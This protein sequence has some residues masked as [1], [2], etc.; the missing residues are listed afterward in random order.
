MR[1]LLAASPEELPCSPGPEPS[2]T[3]RHPSSSAKCVPLHCSS[4]AEVA[5]STGALC[6]G[7]LINKVY[8][9]PAPQCLP[10]QGTCREKRSYFWAI[11]GDSGDERWVPLQTSFSTPQRNWGGGGVSPNPLARTREQDT[12]E[13]RTV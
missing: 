12:G 6:S 10:A 9:P 4:A 2:A 11:Q 5:G 8:N 13:G 7:W 3:L 1:R